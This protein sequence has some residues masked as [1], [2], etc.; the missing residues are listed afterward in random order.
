MIIRRDSKPD[1]K[2]IIFT[3]FV[4]KMSLKYFIFISI[5]KVAACLKIEYVRRCELNR[6]IDKNHDEWDEINMFCVIE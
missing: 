2:N 6:T 5:V 3:T 4:Y 1:E